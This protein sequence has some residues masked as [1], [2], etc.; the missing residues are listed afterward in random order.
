MNFDPMSFVREPDPLGDLIEQVYQRYFNTPRG[1]FHEAC[2][3]IFTMLDSFE[4]V[5]F[6]LHNRRSGYAF[7][8]TNPM[9]EAE[10][11]NTLSELLKL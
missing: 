11:I 9:P 4:T 3:K 1:T 10:A 7:Y 6:P 8:N 2:D 5:E